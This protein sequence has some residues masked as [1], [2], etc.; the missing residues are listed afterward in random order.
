MMTVLNFFASYM[1]HFLG[2]AIAFHI[3]LPNSTPFATFFDSMVKVLAMLM[4]EYEYTINFV[5]ND[6]S[7]FIAKILFVIFVIDMSVVLMNLVLGL[8]ISDI[9]QLQKNSAVRRMI[10]E[11]CTV[12][13]MENLYMILSRIPGLAQ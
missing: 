12:M 11:S 13:F 9:E 7:S 2:Y 10:Q 3:L 5:S 4:G 1:W 6:N 8:A